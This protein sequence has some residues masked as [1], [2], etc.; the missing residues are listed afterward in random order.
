[1]LGI[2]GSFYTYLL[3]EDIVSANP[4]A[5]IRQKSKFI[6]KDN[7]STT[8]IRRLSNKQWATLISVASDMAH[9][10][11]NLHE[12]TLFMIS[13]L[14]GMYL[15]ISELTAH[16]RWTPTMNDFFKDGEDN[17][18]FKTVSKG[19]KARQITVS[20]SVL[21]ALKRYRKHLGLSPYPSSIDEKI[22]L[23]SHINNINKP[24][25]NKRLI[26]ALVQ[27]C[28]DRAVD[29]L[30]TDGDINEAEQLKSATVHWLRHTGI[31]DD[32]K[33]RPRE[34][35][36]DDAGHSSSAITDKYINIELRER[37]KSAKKKKYVELD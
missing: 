1:M 6:R 11:P 13:C 15:R 8:V 20:K 2:L 26:R 12:R 5:L 23:I 30:I 14:Y 4:V 32:V 10:N 29:K 25:N 28:F 17:W 35:V 27:E 37:A 34:H 18:W 7:T 36:R 19:N 9:Q 16:E 22:P 21:R 33:V 24:I 31:S 3:Q